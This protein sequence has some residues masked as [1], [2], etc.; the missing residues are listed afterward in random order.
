M[1]SKLH[2]ITQEVPTYSHDELAEYACAGGVDWVQ[3]RIKNKS[4]NDC[5]AIAIKTE[6]IC[7]KHGAKLIINDNVTLAKAIRADGVH[8]GKADMHP[9]EARKILSDGFIIGGTAN[10]FEDIEK[11]IEAGVDYIGLGPFR[12]TSTK[13]NLSPIL[14]IEG[15][16]Q[17]LKKCSDKGF[18]IPI[19]AIGGIKAEDVK[20]LIQIGLYGIAVSSAINLSENKTETAK[21]FLNKLKIATDKNH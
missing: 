21:R 12:F 10:T 18:N 13:E 9:L 16:E 5:L 2:Y 3:L 17:L 4:Y 15:Y 6:A 7:K 1:I 20:P 11:L 19:I 14:G 8:L